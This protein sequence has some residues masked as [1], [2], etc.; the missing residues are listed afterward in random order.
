MPEICSYECSSCGF[1]VA[2][3]FSGGMYAIDDK[4]ARVPCLHP[5]EFSTAAEVLGISDHELT[6]ALSRLSAASRGEAQPHQSDSERRLDEQVASRVKFTAGYC[7][8]DCCARMELD[9]SLTV[10]TCPSC[11]GNALHAPVESLGRQCP[12]CHAGII[13]EVGMGIMI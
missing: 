12:K 7:C 2:S 1:A 10:R 11:G 8:F 13:R 9:S 3:T 4:G 5:G 6:A